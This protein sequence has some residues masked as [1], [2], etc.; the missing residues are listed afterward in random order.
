[1]S[2]GSR[3]RE[4]RGRRRA[5][6]GRLPLR[7]EVDFGVAE[8][9]EDRHHPGGV[10]LRLDGQEAAHVDLRDPT[11]LAFPYVRRIG[12]LVD[13]AAP[14]GVALD[15]VHLGGG[16]FTMPRY[17][18]ATRPGSHSVV[19]E[20]DEALVRLARAHLSLRTSHRMRVRV[21]D[22]RAGLARLSAASTDVVILDAFAGPLVPAHLT[23]L[24]FVT[25]AHR[26]LRPEGLLVA[27]AI[28]MPPLELARALART[29]SAAFAHVC[30]LADRRILRGDEAGNLVLGATNT[31]LA[32][33]ALR[34][35]A[36]AG[37]DPEGLVAGAELE[38]FAAPGR[39][40]RDGEPFTHRLARLNELWPPAGG[41]R[42]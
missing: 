28:D 41:A 27:N 11:R 25:D 35:R 29:L 21:G 9:A 1:M 23:T 10:L 5:A 16:A 19:F 33:D 31:P 40:L 37:P 32:N 24:E 13:L 42:G 20:H 36:A 17:V 18:A 15:V 4:P 39:V 8:L 30:L 34:A 12:D 14:P 26:V 22:A 6:S 7:A 3:G 2:R 38:A